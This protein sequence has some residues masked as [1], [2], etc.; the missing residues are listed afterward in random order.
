MRRRR[1]VPRKYMPS[2]MPVVG[3]LTWWTFLTVI[4][5]PMWAW[6]AVGTLVALGWIGVLVDM[7]TEEELPL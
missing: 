4:E 7:W 5:A 1:V 2:R 6:G 3:T